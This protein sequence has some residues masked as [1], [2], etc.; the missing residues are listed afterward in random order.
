MPG[1]EYVINKGINSEIEF[2]GLRGQWIYYLG[3]GLAA[4]LI[5][6]VI[7]YLCGVNTFICLSI[8]GGIGGY[9]FRW[10]YRSNAKFGSDGLTKKRARQLLPHVIKNNSRK[11]FFKKER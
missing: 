11:I 5:V 1:S 7:L 3:A 6:F 2:K 8:V 9:L 10:V 4:L